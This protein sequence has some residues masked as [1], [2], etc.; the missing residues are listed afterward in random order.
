[1]RKLEGIIVLLIST[2]GEDKLW[3]SMV[4]MT[5]VLRAINS[6]G[7]GRSDGDNIQC[8]LGRGLANST[9]IDRF[10]PLKV[11]HLPRFG[12]D[13]AA[14]S[15]VLDATSCLEERKRKYVFKFEDV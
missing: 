13:H 2:S 11:Q 14:I 9:V 10:S 15:I 4:S 1:M 8:R 3:S 12:S 5:L 6:R 7:H